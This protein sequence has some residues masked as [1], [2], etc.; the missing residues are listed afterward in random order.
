MPGNSA[1]FHGDWDALLARFAQRREKDAPGP[2]KLAQ[3]QEEALK[4]R[5]RKPVDPH[6]A[7]FE[8]ATAD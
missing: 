5:V 3:A 8:R 6:Q 7:L 4:S 1:S 2:D